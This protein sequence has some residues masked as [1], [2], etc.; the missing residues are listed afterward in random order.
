MERVNKIKGSFDEAVKITKTEIASSVSVFKESMDELKISNFLK[1]AVSEELKF[2]KY[3]KHEV[4]SVSE[5]CKS[6]TRIDEVT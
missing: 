1:V 6:I 5:D 4:Y 3:L 2:S